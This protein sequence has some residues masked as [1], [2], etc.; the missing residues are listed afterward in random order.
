MNQVCDA[1]LQTV[2]SVQPHGP[3]DA[4]GYFA[5]RHLG[6]GHCGPFAGQRGRGG[7]P[8]AADTHPPETQ[9]WDVM[10]DDNVLKEI[11]RERQQFIAVSEGAL[12]PTDQGEKTSMFDKIEANYADSVRLLSAT[13]TVRFNG[14]ATLF[15]VATPYLAGGNGRSADLVTLCGFSYVHELDCAHVDIVSPASF[16]ILGPMLNRILRAL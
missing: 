14:E 8:R 6:A 15:V 3:H 4:I 13:H 2:L 10:L 5:G 7:V 11:Q 16:K 1:H 12:D 9:S